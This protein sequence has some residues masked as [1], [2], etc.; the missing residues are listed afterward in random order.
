MEFELCYPEWK[1]MA[2]TFSYDDAQVTDRR[3]VEIFN[4]YGLK[5]TF[6][7]NSGRLDQDIFIASSEVKDLYKGHEVACHGVTH[8]Y[9]THLAQEQL[10]Q[11]F[12]QDRCRLEELTGSLVRGCSYAYGEYDERVIN[13]LKS[14]GIVYSRT[15]ESTGGFAVPSDFMRWRPTCHHNDAF[16]GIAERFLSKPFYVKLTLLYVWG[17]SFEFENDNTWDRMEDFCRKISGHENVWYTTNIG[18][19]EYFTAARRLV[20]SADRSIVWNPS[21]TKIYAIVDGEKKIL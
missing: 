4:R 5:A 18:F 14:V 1:K 3:L 2:V 21:A 17:H 11:E 10:L 8:A 6:H 16:N 20:F 7:V 13:T 15:V 19:Y 12:Y 9:P